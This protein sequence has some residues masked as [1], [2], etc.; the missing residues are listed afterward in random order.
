MNRTLRIG[1]VAV[2]SLL[3]LAIQSGHSQ[4]G[5]PGGGIRG[6][7]PINTGMPGPPGGIGG[8]NSGR[9]NPGG[10]LP[11]PPLQPPIGG[12]PAN[13]GEDGPLAGMILPPA[14][15]ANAPPAEAYVP[16]TYENSSTNRSTTAK[17]IFITL[18]MLILLAI[19]HRR[20][21]LRDCETTR[22][23]ASPQSSATYVG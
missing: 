2:A 19:G 22:K 10:I 14:P 16:P 1:I 12:M 23:K 15:P 20:S 9:P 18:A 21:H 5:G 7:P 3:T 13:P 11:T 17:W 4:I 8:G 6:G